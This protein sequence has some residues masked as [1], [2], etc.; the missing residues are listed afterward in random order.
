MTAVLIARRNSRVVVDGI[1]RQIR[2]GRTTAHADAGVVLEHPD[3][4]EPFR[5]DFPATVAATVTA[6]AAPVRHEEPEPVAAT[7]QASEAP[8][9]AQASTEG[10]PPAKDVRAWARAEGLD[11]PARGPL[12]DELVA[13]Y[14]EARGVVGA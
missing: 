12:P 11:V 6:E 4:W 9:G 10:R 3:L 8:A 1:P 7:D 14:R 5:V 2:R 13:A